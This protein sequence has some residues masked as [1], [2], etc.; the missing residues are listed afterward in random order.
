M[1]T[2]PLEIP[3]RL[4]L[5]CLKVLW[6]LESATVKQVQEFLNKDRRLAYTTIMTVLER[7]V[8]RGLVARRKQGRSFVYMPVVDRNA[9]RRVAVSQLLED[10]FDGSVSDLIR[11]LDFTEPGTR[12]S[13]PAQRRETEA[14]S[15]FVET[16]EPG[17]LEPELL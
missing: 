8:R 7:L 1:R 2:F 3:P 9:L 6:R 14:T 16:I 15:S 11:F 17:R 5:E 12:L 4:E 13:Q 10:F